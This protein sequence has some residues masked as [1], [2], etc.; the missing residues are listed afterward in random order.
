MLKRMLQ[1]HTFKYKGPRDTEK[2]A[3]H[4][5]DRLKD[6]AKDGWKGSGKHVRTRRETKRSASSNGCCSVVVTDSVAESLAI[7]DDK[8]DGSKANNKRRFN[9]ED[10]IECTASMHEGSGKEIARGNRQDNGGGTEREGTRR[11]V[12]NTHVPVF[13][14]GGNPKK[15]VPRNVARFDAEAYKA[16]RRFVPSVHG[17]NPGFNH[18]DDGA[19]FMDGEEMFGEDGEGLSR[20]EGGGFSWEGMGTIS[21]R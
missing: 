7:D 1:S 17:G 5:E 20:Y 15:R 19:G 14:L 9:G 8:K 16:R 12:E 11:R 21:Y 13:V 2:A 6:N 3:K 10:A 4:G 18:Y